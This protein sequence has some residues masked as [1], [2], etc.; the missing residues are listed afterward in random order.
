MYLADTLSD[1]AKNDPSMIPHLQAVLRDLP[2]SDR[3]TKTDFRNI[4]EYQASIDVLKSQSV[5]AK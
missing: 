1:F 3:G 2:Y 5:T 4:E